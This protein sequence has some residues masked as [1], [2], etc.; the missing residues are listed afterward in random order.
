[1]GVLDAG[2][3]YVSSLYVRVMREGPISVLCEC[4]ISV[5]CVSVL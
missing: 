3:L 4:P 1:M 2:V 5:L